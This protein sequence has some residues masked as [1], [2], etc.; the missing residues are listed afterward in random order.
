M[1]ALVKHKAGHEV[2]DTEIMTRS[3]HEA[4][5]ALDGPTL[6]DGETRQIRIG[7]IAIAAKRSIQPQEGM[8]WLGAGVERFAFDNAGLTAIAAVD[9]MTHPAGARV[10][11]DEIR[12][13]PIPRVLSYAETRE[14]GSVVMTRDLE[15]VLQTA[16]NGGEVRM[17]DIERLEQLAAAVVM[18]PEEA[19][20]HGGARQYDKGGPNSADVIHDAASHLWQSLMSSDVVVAYAS[21]VLDHA[22]DREQQDGARPPT[23]AKGYLDAGRRARLLGDHLLFGQE[24]LPPSIAPAIEQA[25]ASSVLREA[26]KTIR[27]PGGASRPDSR[28]E[29]SR[30]TMGTL[31]DKKQAA[32]DALDHLLGEQVCTGFEKAKALREIGESS[33]RMAKN[34]EQWS[35]ESA[36]LIDG[37]GAT[38]VTMGT[39]AMQVSEQ[40]AKAREKLE[41]TSDDSYA[42]QNE[43]RD[44]IGFLEDFS[45]KIRKAVPGG[46][47]D[48]SVQ[49]EDYGYDAE[50]AAADQSCGLEY[51]PAIE[52]ERSAHAMDLASVQDIINSLRKMGV[53]VRTEFTVIAPPEMYSEEEED[54]QADT[55]PGF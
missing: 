13:Q 51:V 23:W 29:E 40:T 53:K 30:P 34:V 24:T 55:S 41:D 18:G 5:E 14:V 21:A 27:E 36:R 42:T 7:G 2:A 11:H 10:R 54:E 25:P 50:E 39:L 4:L 19:R 52:R 48:L 20:W 15:A 49:V 37:N 43:L 28:T 38:V 3:L 44:R 32:L 1:Y 31:R 6:A 9:A 17:D 26:A 35:R 8:A 16:E 12:L 33:S 46:T 45:K 22:L 47:L